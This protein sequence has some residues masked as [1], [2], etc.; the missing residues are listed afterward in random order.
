MINL[1]RKSSWLLCF[2]L[3]CG[4][5]TVCVGLFG[6][7]LSVTGRLCFDIMPLQL[8]YYFIRKLECIPD[9]VSLQ[10]EIY[11][12][13]RSKAYLRAYTHSAYPDQPA[14]PRSLIRAFAVR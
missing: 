11:G 2:S 1:F 13:H 14:H 7:S 12:P 5:H 10:L 8:L 9:N 4:L 3:S 6:P